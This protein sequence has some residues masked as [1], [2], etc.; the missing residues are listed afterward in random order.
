MLVMLDAPSICARNVVS[1]AEPSPSGN[2]V[3]QYARRNDRAWEKEPGTHEGGGGWGG[4]KVVQSFARPGSAPPSTNLTNRKAKHEMQ[5]V[6]KRPTATLRRVIAR[7]AILGGNEGMQ[8]SLTFPRGS[9]L[10][11][12][13]GMVNMGC[14]ARMVKIGH[15]RG[16]CVLGY[17]CR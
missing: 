11:A 8:T 6:C 14:D 15:Q 9:G 2:P 1:A 17:A 4:G 16:Q 10:P 13:Q 7:A 3:F 12:N 5:E